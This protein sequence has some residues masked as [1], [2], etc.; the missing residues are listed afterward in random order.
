MGTNSLYI[1]KDMLKSGVFRSLN[2]T[3][4]IVY[5]DFR[6]KVKVQ[7]TKGTRLKKSEWIILN[8]GELEYTYAEAEAKG[9]KR[10]R[11]I[12]ALRELVEKGFIDVAHAGSGGIKGDKSK[13]AISER[14]RDYGTDKFLKA[15]M[16][17]DTRQG[18]GF[19]VYWRKKKTNIGNVSVTRPNNVDVTPLKKKKTN[20]VTQTLLQ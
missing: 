15:T 4:I 13:Y 18:R 8:N 10:P 1:P 2:G 11:F 3:S 5:F 9:I 17:K 6:V 14:W 7:K 12:R 16:P 19:S 20:E